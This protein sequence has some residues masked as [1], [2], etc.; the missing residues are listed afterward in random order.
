MK[1]FSVLFFLLITSSVFAK[2]I[3]TNFNLYAIEVKQGDI[4]KILFHQKRVLNYKLELK[5]NKN[6]NN[7]GITA[8]G[9]LFSFLPLTDVREN[10]QTA[11]K[12]RLNFKADNKMIFPVRVTTVNN[13]LLTFS[14]NNITVIN[15]EQWKLTLKGECLKSDVTPNK[16]IQSTDVYNLN[17]NVSRQTP[18]MLNVLSNSDL[19]IDT[20]AMTIQ[21]NQ[22]ISNGLTNMR[23]LTNRSSLKFEIKG[24]KNAKKR[25]LILHYLN[26]VVNTLFR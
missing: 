2:S 11:L 24:I 25:A 7:Q 14:G 19:I 1:K 3:W 21:T 16:T 17:F 22:T 18:K 20:N 26:T 8:N 4:L 15:G 5:D 10:D 12:K 9:Q 13:G 6:M 23:V